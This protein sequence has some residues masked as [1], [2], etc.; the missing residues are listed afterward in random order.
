MLSIIMLRSIIQE[1][2]L[3]LS[4]NAMSLTPMT[5]NKTTLSILGLI[6]NS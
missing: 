3:C 4:H 5:L 2:K 1:I 6:G